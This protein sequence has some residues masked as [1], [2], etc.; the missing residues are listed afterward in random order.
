MNHTSPRVNVLTR[1]FN[2]HRLAHTVVALVIMSTMIPC[3]VLVGA[4]NGFMGTGVVV[5]VCAGVALALLS[6]GFVLHAFM[7]TVRCGLAVWGSR[8]R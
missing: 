7:A 3:A 2:K 1:D 6:Y 5:V 4:S 8:S